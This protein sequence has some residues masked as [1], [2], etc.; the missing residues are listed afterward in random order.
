MFYPIIILYPDTN[1]SAG[2]DSFVSFFYV[3]A[4]FNIGLID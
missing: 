4:C 2:P 1:N 3:F